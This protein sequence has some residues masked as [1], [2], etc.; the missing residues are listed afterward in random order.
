[1]TMASPLPTCGLQMTVADVVAHHDVVAGDTLTDL[2]LTKLGDVNLW[3]DLAQLNQLCAPYQLN[4]GQ[5]LIVPDF[6]RHDVTI[7]YMH[8]EMITNCGSTEVQEIQQA[9]QRAQNFDAEARRYY[10][11]AADDPW[12]QAL[13]SLGKIK[14][15]D[16]LTNAAAVARLEAKGRWF[17]QVRANGPWDHKPILRGMYQRMSNPPGSYGQLSRAYHFPIRGDVFN[18]YYYD[19]WSNIHYGFVGMCAGFDENT[20]QNAAN[21]GLPGFGDNDQGDFIST[22]IGIDLWK[23]YGLAVTQENIRQA[24]VNAGASFVAARS[25]EIAKGTPSSEA[26]NVVIQNNDYK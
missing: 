9:H 19:I 18:E 8:S 10:A 16:N 21:L 13:A 23:Q 7:V 2:A 1:M 26:T 6:T 3:M 4:V 24:I 25:A 22:Q 5:R 17:V 12:Y 20:L 11:D 14:A 15:G